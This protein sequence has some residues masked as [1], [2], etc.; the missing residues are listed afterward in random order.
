MKSKFT[1]GLL[2]PRYF[3]FYAHEVVA[4]MVDYASQHQHIHFCNL[5]FNT[6]ASAENKV[7][8]AQVDGLILGLNAAEYNTLKNALPRDVPMINL[9]P[10][11]LHSNIPTVCV[12]I[13][14]KC[15]VAFD[16]ITGLGYRHIASSG[17]TCGGDWEEVSAEM[18][19]LSAEHGLS[20][21]SLGMELPRLVYSESDSLPPI[22]KLDDW[23][24]SLPKPVGILSSGGYSA[25][26]I[27]KSVSRLGFR[28]PQDITILSQSDDEIC[29]FADPPISSIKNLGTE[30][31]EIALSILDKTFS[32]NP[33]PKGR[34]TIESAGVIERRSTGFPA[35]MP[36]EIK[37]AIIY[38][39]NHACEG[40]SVDDII[41]N[42]RTIS[43]TRLYEEFP[44]YFNKSP[45]A[46]I[47]SVRIA[48]A[49]RQLADT[50]LSIGMIGE[51][52]GFSSHSQFTDAFRRK[53]HISPL[54]WRKKHSKDSSQKT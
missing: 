20:Y 18:Q 26:F 25:T 27:E 41:K 40:I 54:A 17:D 32:G 44:I 51:K 42:V 2:L 15:R 9:H 39:R 53:M 49:I 50:N 13:K 35:G 5:Q 21:S 29:L 28:V 8:D 52:C 10:A 12:D 33:H 24:K 7:P 48:A 46:E 6:L 38:I 34:I 14:S 16:Y 30:I 19:K 47:M 3:K 37:R 43:R 45:A 36:D 22:R 11:I 4:G 23:L 31:G 1:V